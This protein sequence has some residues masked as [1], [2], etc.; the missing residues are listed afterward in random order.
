[1]SRPCARCTRATASNQALKEIDGGAASA[2]VKADEKEPG[3]A[4]WRLRRTRRTRRAN[5][6]R[7]RCCARDY[8]CVLT[9]AQLEAWRG[10]M[11]PK[12]SPSIQKPTR[13]IRCARNLVGISLSV[14]PGK[15]CYIPLAHSAPASPRNCRAMVLAVAS[16]AG[17]SGEE[18]PRPARQIRHP[19]RRH[20]I[21]LQGLC[22]RH[23][24]GKLRAECRHRAARHGFAGTAPPGYQTVKYGTWSARVPSRSASPRSRW[25]MPPVTPP[26]MPTSPAAC[27]ACCCRSCR[28]S[29]SC[30]RCTAR[31]RCRW[32]RCWRG[33]RPTG[34][35]R[36]RRTAPAIRRELS[37]RMLAAQQ[38][39]PNW[40]RRSFN[41][42]RRSSLR[43]L[44]F[45]ELKLPALVKTPAASLDEEAL[46]AIADQ[47][48]LPRIIP[49]V[50]RPKLRSTY[51][52]KLPEM[53]NPGHRPR[54]PATTRPAPRP[55]GCRRPIP[56]CRT[57]PPRAA[58]I[59][60][61]R[62]AA[63]AQA[64]GRDYSQIELRIMAHL[65]ED[66]TCWWVPSR[67]ALTSIARPRRRCSAK[68]AGRREA[69]R[70]A[71]PR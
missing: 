16:A 70:A 8:A 53:V 50:P 14:K 41:L 11:P 45:D 26:K 12:N 27:I 43:A 52:D 35:D 5:R 17:R 44:L 7:S 64:G 33:S 3:V 6:D 28:P 65:S 25:T 55:G 63:R 23:H 61:V 58:R 60:R 59:H 42:I 20:G 22:R 34:D 9:L 4:R 49:G 21:D 47:H 24:A 38:R 19:L 54:A 30:C 18:K 31:S 57:S 1:M 51:T 13:W 48:E 36:W 29:R 37:R 66:A 69:V 46:E 39:R 62:R 71:R 56:T 67:A 15:A 68:T 10:C 32:C 40:R 2:S